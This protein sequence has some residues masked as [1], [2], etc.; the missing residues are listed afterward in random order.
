MPRQVQD[1]LMHYLNTSHGSPHRGAHKL[2]VEATNAYDK[3]R[4]KVRSFIGARFS[5]ECVFTRNSTESLNLIAYGY[6]RHTLKPGDK[7][8]TAITAH[9][10]GILPL[11]MISEETGATLEYL[12]CDD[13]G[14]IPVKQLEKI[15]LDTKYVL[16][17]LISNG[18][19]VVH[20]VRLISEKA[21][22]VGAVFAVDGAQAVGH[23]PVDVQSLQADLFLFSGH[24]ILG[25]QGI[26]V[27]YGRKEILES[28]KPFLRGGDMIEYV[29]EQSATYAP[30][31]ER[32]EAGTQN[33]FGAVGLHAALD[34][35][36][37]LGVQ[38]IRDFEHD[39]TTYAFSRL[40]N[41]KGVSIY[42]PNSSQ[43]RGSLITFNVDGIHPHDVASILDHYGVAI[44]AGHHCC[45]PLMKHLGLTSTCRVSFS[46]YNTRNEV[47]QFIDAL[48][49]TQEVF[50]N[51]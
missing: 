33:V 51:A 21:K 2:S 47:D 12:Y 9:H 35:V 30:L 18:L 17:P 19:G 15:D 49:K 46:L 24:K 43:E 38:N 1:A 45:Q 20:D 8:V 11:Q 14:R 41:M 6:L 40:K 3:A 26:G 31:P 25:P 22:S 7:M 28:F 34:Y 36:D 48:Q 4:E 16:V 50:G 44:R 13:D 42:G 37:T 5:E 29:E 32:L 39:L 10:S 23:I 27:L